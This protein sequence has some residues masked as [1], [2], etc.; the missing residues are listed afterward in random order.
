MDSLKWSKE[1]ACTAC[2]EYRST[3]Q[4]E[5]LLCQPFTAKYSSIPQTVI[6]ILTPYSCS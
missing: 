1:A 6:L 4:E 5:D 3:W 2:S